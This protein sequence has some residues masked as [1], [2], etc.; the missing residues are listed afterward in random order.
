MTGAVFVMSAEL[1]VLLGT[2]VTDVVDTD[3][4]MSRV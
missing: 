2:D 1:G 4:I 3:G